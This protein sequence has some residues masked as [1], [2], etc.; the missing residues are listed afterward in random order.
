M[1]EKDELKKRKQGIGQEIDPADDD[2]CDL[3]PRKKCDN[4]FRCLGLDALENEGYA[5]IPIAGVFLDD[6]I[7][8]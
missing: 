6:E 2:R 5:K 4:C 1:E 7:N 8:I 3:D